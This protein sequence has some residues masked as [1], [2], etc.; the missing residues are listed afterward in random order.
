ML[1]DRDCRVA[2]LVDSSA[3]LP[4]EEVAA[5]AITVVP[6]TITWGGEALRD[7]VDISPAD[8]WRRLVVDPQL[9]TT[10]AT[11]P[12]V[13][14]EALD[15]VRSW[16]SS[17]VCLTLPSR[18]SAVHASARLAAREIAAEFRATVVETGGT[19]M[20]LGFPA[21]LAARAASAGARHDEVV[22][23]A[24]EAAAGARL[25]A[26]L[27]SLEYVARSGRVPGVVARLADASP[28]R[29]VLSLRG[30]RVHTRFR[31]GSRERAVDAMVRE[32]ARQAGGSRYVGVAVHYGSD[33]DEAAALAGRVRASLAVDDCFTTSFT[34]V[35]G[36]HTGPGLLGIASCVLG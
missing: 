10:S 27:D 25:V 7:G 9:P 34:P 26:V 35:M 11:S 29:V 24:G 15:R 30:G 33:V 17:A 6:M 20:A 1:A 23:I 32:V 19:A 5:H 36:V 13:W 4:A 28:S 3:C 18:L 31:L 14:L 16:A 12:G 8:F 21:L 22:R 2:V